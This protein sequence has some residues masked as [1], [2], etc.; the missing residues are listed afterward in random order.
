MAGSKY[1]DTTAIIQII[2][3]VYNNPTILDCTDK[4]SITE[5]DFPDTFIK[6]YLAQYLNYMSLGQKRLLLKL[7]QTF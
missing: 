6:S 3:C 5:E 7:F 4:Y 1:V 2:G